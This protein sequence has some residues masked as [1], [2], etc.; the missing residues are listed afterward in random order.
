MMAGSEH[1]VKKIPT[2]TRPAKVSLALLA[3]LTLTSACGSSSTPTSPSTPVTQ[4]FSSNIQ[5]LGAA[6]QS[7]VAALDGTVTLTLS[8]V[9][10]GVTM[11]LGFGKFDATT[12]CKMTSTVETTGGADP[13]ITV[14]VTAG[15]YCTRIYDVGNLTTNTTFVITIVRP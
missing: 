13:Q 5:P 4:T 9:G 12:G 14:S 11:G 6:S 8:T 15:T 10:A 1:V 3:V 2:L 7:F